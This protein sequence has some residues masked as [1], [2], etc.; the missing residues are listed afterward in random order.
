M[1]L[2]Q[3]LLWAR[4]WCRNGAMGYR[5]SLLLE[6]DNA[7]LGLVGAAIAPLGTTCGPG[8]FK[9]AGARKDVSLGWE[10]WLHWGT[11]ELVARC[12]PWHRSP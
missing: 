2:Q 5:D 6:G 1:S 10:L 9:A 12:E 3:H 7:K 4:G 8:P 11:A